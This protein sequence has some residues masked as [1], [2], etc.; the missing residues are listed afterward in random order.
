M[1]KNGS[2]SATG[3]TNDNNSVRNKSSI[4]LIET[5]QPSDLDDVDEDQS[6]DQYSDVFHT[7]IQS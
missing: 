2:S 4:Q 1:I 3:V 7:D 5:E 6:F